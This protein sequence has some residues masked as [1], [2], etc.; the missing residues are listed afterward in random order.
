MK[1]CSLFLIGLLAYS[2]PSRLKDLV[3]LEGV[4]DN[5]LIGYGIVVGLAGTGDKQLTLFSTQ[6]LTNMLKRMGVTV[7]PT[8]MQVR[9]M[10]SVMVSANLPPFA[11]PGI[12]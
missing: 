3:S 10:A 5:Q 4:R 6:S 1:R 12:K 11:Q 8:Q 9:N 7:D 2:E